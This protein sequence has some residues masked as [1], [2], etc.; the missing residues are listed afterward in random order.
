MTLHETYQPFNGQVHRRVPA[1]NVSRLRSI[2]ND[3]AMAA[4]KGDL[5]ANSAF[6]KIGPLLMRKDFQLRS[7]HRIHKIIARRLRLWEEGDFTTLV[8]EYLADELRRAINDFGIAPHTE[9]EKKLLKR[10]DVLIAEGLLGKAVQLLNSV[11][12][13]KYSV[14]MEQRLRVLFPQTNAEITGDFDLWQEPAN[15]EFPEPTTHTF[16]SLIRSAKKDSATDMHGFRMDWIKDICPTEEKTPKTD[17]DRGEAWDLNEGA[18]AGIRMLA[19]RIGAPRIPGFTSAM[20]ELEASGLLVA[21]AKKDGTERPIGIGSVMRRLGGSVLLKMSKA[22]LKAYYEPRG[23]MCLG[24]RNAPEKC[25]IAHNAKLAQD[26]TRTVYAADERNGFGC[27]SQKAVL[28]G[29]EQLPANLQW[30][31]YTFGMY[32]RGTPKLLFR[33]GT[34]S[35]YVLCLVGFQQ[36]DPLG[37][38]YFSA[39]A[40][41]SLVKMRGDFPDDN[42]QAYADDVHGC[43]PDNA[44]VQCA[45]DGRGY[46]LIPF[47]EGA[48]DMPAAAARLRRWGD[49]AAEANLEV[50]HDKCYV[51]SPQTDLDQAEFGDI[52]CRDGLLILGIP[53]GTAQYVKET[54]TALANKA[55]AVSFRATERIQHLQSRALADLHC[56]GSPKIGHLLRIVTPTAT[57]EARKINDAETLKAF[58]RLLDVPSLTDIQ[59]KQSSLPLRLGGNGLRYTGQYKLAALVAGWVAALFPR[60]D[61]DFVVSDIAP[62][63]AQLSDNVDNIDFIFPQLQ[64]VIAAWKALVNSSPTIKMLAEAAALDAVSSAMIKDLE[65][66]FKAE[67]IQ[68]RKP[69]V[70]PSNCDPLGRPLDTDGEVKRGG[71]MVKLGVPRG[72]NKTLS[73]KQCMHVIS[74][75]TK[76]ALLKDDVPD[77]DRRMHADPAAHF[78][79]VKK[80]MATWCLLHQPEDPFDKPESSLQSL[81]THILERERFKDMMDNH[82]HP[83]AKDVI[84]HRSLLDPKATIP[85]IALPSTRHRFSNEEFIYIIRARL[86]IPMRIAPSLP[87]RCTCGSKSD[88]RGGDHLVCCKKGGG[89]YFI[90]N[91]LRN[92]LLNCARSAGKVATVETRH[93]IAGCD[94]RPADVFIHNFIDGK[95]TCV[96]ITRTSTH[97]SVRSGHFLE[98][99][100]NEPGAAAALAERRKRQHKICVGGISTVAA[101]EAAGYAFYPLAFNDSGSTS[102]AFCTILKKLSKHAEKYRMVNRRH[103]E[104]KWTTQFAMTNAKVGANYALRRGLAVIQETN[105]SHLDAMAFEGEGN[106][107]E[108]VASFGS[109]PASV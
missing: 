75:S 26:G 8:C 53:I 6:K 90:H 23:Q 76:D 44:R 69:T 62:S 86:G 77:L 2:L 50:R 48:T 58:L 39:G 59:H 93:L 97:A 109:L 88:M 70:P 20:W 56:S 7:K 85:L 15:L 43:T 74:Q 4:S 82:E 42:I 51:F 108:D 107:N 55:M 65:D 80:I 92:V 52:R 67:I 94:A 79:I 28:K 60:S 72:E 46:A 54:V 45:D 102:D 100:S 27:I 10:V 49:I 32:Y 89:P 16:C 73:Y 35:F 96:D 40:D 17:A 19:T 105:E 3:V 30:I 47:V 81:F 29:L 14:E 84:R 25:A 61:A 34:N 71:K 103:W 37:C 98:R 38:I 91:A 12:L 31:R 66:A 41:G 63:L 95:D 101:V 64:E 21:P 83:T 36:G 99:L 18:M 104:R 13:A 78:G 57:A 33:S 24:T 9:E 68:G 5:S 106:S 87:A 11:G 1:Q 22:D